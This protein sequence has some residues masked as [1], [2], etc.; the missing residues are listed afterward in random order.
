MAWPRPRFAP[1]AW[2]AAA[3]AGCLAWPAATAQQARSELSPTERCLTLAADAPDTAPAYP[4]EAFKRGIPGRVKAELVFTLPDRPPAVSILD[5]ASGEPGKPS[6]LSPSDFEG[7]VRSFARQYR[8]PCLT[9]PEV[10]ARF[11][12]EYVFRPDRREAQ[13]DQPTDLDRQARD[14]LWRCVRRAGGGDLQPAYP[15]SALRS[16]V[17][18]RVLVRMK[19]TSPD[20]PPEA[21]VMA[22]PVARDLA[23]Y[24]RSWV[25]DLRLPCLSGGPYETTVSYFFLMEGS[26]YGFKPGVGFLQLLR[27]VSPAGR[28]QMPPDTT[29]MDCPFDVRLN[30]TQPHRPNRVASLSP[31]NPSRRP[32]LDWLSTLEFDLPAKSRDSVFGDDVT[33][34]IPCLKIQSPL[35]ES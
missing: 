10:P 29:A 34:T 5:S 24:I 16:G 14:A 6:D 1:P 19:F 12:V 32:F 33:F 9:P 18:G 28:A 26:A 4:F 2:V 3:L 17:Q 35:K 8:V 25:A 11:S 23:D 22:R 21:E 30:Y 13:H 20:A 31:W 27:A 15:A 7:A